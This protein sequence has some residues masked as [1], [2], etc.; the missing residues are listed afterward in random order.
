MYPQRC[1]RPPPQMVDIRCCR[2]P[3]RQ[4]MRV[5]TNS[6]S[7]VSVMRAADG[8]DGLWKLPDVV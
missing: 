6:M 4:M 3:L 7:H 8:F 1:T 2:V 5:V